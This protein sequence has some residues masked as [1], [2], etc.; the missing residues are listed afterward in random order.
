M[1]LQT[2]FRVVGPHWTLDGYRGAHGTVAAHRTQ[3]PCT[4]GRVRA[5]RAKLT[6]ESSQASLEGFGLAH[7]GAVGAWITKR[8]F[9][10]CTQ[11]GLVAIATLWTVLTCL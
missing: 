1:I 7:G 3:V 8:T 11:T 6:V 2:F 5:V 4:V 9:S 10:G